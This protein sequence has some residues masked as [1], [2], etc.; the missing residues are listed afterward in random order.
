MVDGKKTWAI[1]NWVEKSS[2]ETRSIV[3]DAMQDSPF[4]YGPYG[5]P[6]AQWSMAFIGSTAD[7][8]KAE[9]S[10]SLLPLSNEETLPINWDLCLDGAGQAMFFRRLKISF[11]MNTAII[12]EVRDKRKYRMSMDDMTSLRHLCALWQQLRAFCSTRMADFDAFEK[13]LMT[14]SSVDDQFH[15]VLQECP[16]MFALSMLPLTQRAALG[17]LKQKEEDATVEVEKQ[18]L[19]VRNAKWKYF[20]AALVRDQRQMA[21]ISAAPDKLQALRHR[22]EMAWRLEQAKIGERIVLAYQEKFLRCRQV[23]QLQHLHE[24]LHEY[25]A[26]VV[27]W[28]QWSPHMLS[29]VERCPSTKPLSNSARVVLPSILGRCGR[30]E[31]ERPLHGDIC[32]LKCPPCQQQGENDGADA[33]CCVHQ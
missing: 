26:F 19:E 18:R 25:R 29:I 16:P 12:S 15:S 8:L 31:D 10:S 24:V 30:S 11:D 1:K 2:K 20:Q 6:V 14:G 5:E 13:K 21:L 3:L 22:K 9:P 32:G 33:G 4:Q 27:I 23:Q 7:D 28:L 17:E